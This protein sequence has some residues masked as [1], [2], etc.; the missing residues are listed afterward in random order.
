MFL[1]LP[2]KI[3]VELLLAAGSMQPVRLIM[4]KDDVEFD[5]KVEFVNRIK[6]DIENIKNQE[7]REHSLIL[8]KKIL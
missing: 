5:G 7:A 6:I 2:R 1:Q 4:I 8:R 3:T